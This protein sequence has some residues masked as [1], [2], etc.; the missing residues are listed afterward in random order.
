M[1][2]LFQIP[3]LVLT[4]LL[5]GTV[6][7]HLLTGQG[8]LHSFYQAF[9]LLATVGSQEP[10]PLTDATMVFII[11]YLASGLG[12]FAYSAIQFGKVLVNADFR[13]LLERRR[14]ERQIN[15]LTGHFIICGFGRMG[16]ELCSYLHQRRQPFVIIDEN[17]EL[18]TP[19]MRRDEWLFL[20]GDATQDDI[21]QEAGI[22]RARALTTVLPTNAD[23]LYVVLS[24]RL[25]SGE[26]QIVARASDDRAAQKMQQAGATRV[27]NP[28]SSGAIRMA[29]FMLSPSIEN[30]VEVAESEGVDWEIA[31]VHVPD[32]SPLVD[33]Q[34]KETNLRQEGIMLLGVCRESGE[35]FF[36]PPGDLRIHSGD[37]L[38]AFGSSDNL[39]SLTDMMEVAP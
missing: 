18:V 21:L 12:V 34:L 26:L 39:R 4:I 20:Q 24:S 3:F 28:L 36:P 8:I 38:F 22:A 37:N 19:E 15:K 7:L 16:R 11:V 25:L 17:A 13:V 31:D 27:I 33:Q 23:N 1:R 35:K 6:G 10:Q 32:D 2:N 9:I 30:F 14:M 29:R 5:G